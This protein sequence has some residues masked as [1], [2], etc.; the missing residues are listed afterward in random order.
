ML[1]LSMLIFNILFL[2]NA[3]GICASIQYAVS[4]ST[5]HTGSIRSKPLNQK[6]SRVAFRERSCALS[7]SSSFHDV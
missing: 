1:T 5:K 3:V 2:N 7:I 4:L 6:E